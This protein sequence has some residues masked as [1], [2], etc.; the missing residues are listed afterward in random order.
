MVPRRT[1]NKKLALKELNAADERLTNMIGDLINQ[2][3]S[4][5]MFTAIFRTRNGEKKAC[6][7]YVMYEDELFTILPHR[8]KR[9]YNPNVS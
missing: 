4:L 3:D 2:R 1:V 5:R 8:V 6:D 7:T 9:L